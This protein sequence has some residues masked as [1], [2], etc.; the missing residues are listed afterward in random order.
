MRSILSECERMED[1]ADP[2]CVM[3]GLKRPDFYRNLMGDMEPVTCD[4][5]HIRASL[6]ETKRSLDAPM[7]DAITEAT[8][9]VAAEF[10]ESPAECQAVIWCTVRPSG[11]GQ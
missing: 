4:R 6:G 1:G 5:W 11:N 10:G 8:R 9:I 3:S 2:A 7:R